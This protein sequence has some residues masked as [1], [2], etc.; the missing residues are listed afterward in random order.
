MSKLVPHAPV[1]L[2]L[3]RGGGDAFIVEHSDDFVTVASSAPS[4]PGSTLEATHRGDARLT[5]VRVKVRGCRRAPLPDGREGFR[6]EGR[7]VSLTRADR[8]ALFGSQTE[9]KSGSTSET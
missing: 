8:E 1:P 3:Q 9:A 7:F 6:I 4:P 5:T 2:Q